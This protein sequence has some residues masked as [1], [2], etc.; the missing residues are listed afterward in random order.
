MTL[1]V[2]VALLRDSADAVLR[3]A[4]D[5]DTAASSIPDAADTGIGAPAL[6]GILALFTGRGGELQT[7]LASYSAAL[8]ECASEY[9]TQD[10]TTAEEVN[11]ALWEQ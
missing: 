4:D 3:I 7:A 6:A 10:V 1:Y 5:F 2:E 11:A 9:E 8:D